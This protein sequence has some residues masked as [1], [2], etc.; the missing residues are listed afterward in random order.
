MSTDVH[1]SGTAILKGQ[2]LRLQCLSNAMYQRWYSM[3][4]SEP[5]DVINLNRCIVHRSHMIKIFLI[6]GKKN[7]IHV[8]NDGYIFKMPLNTIPRNSIIV[9]NPRKQ[10]TR[11]FKHFKTLQRP[12]T[13]Q[14][15][16]RGS[17]FYMHS[18]IYIQNGTKDFSLQPWPHYAQSSYSWQLTDHGI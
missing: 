14:L 7:G 11:F 3:I 5:S 16:A 18:C 2:E 6:I 8:N 4:Y 9:E 17:N 13:R 12:Y 10:Y 15:L 1:Y